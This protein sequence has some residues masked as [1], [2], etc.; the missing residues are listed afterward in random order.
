MYYKFSRRY[1]PELNSFLAAA[2]TI[3]KFNRRNI[4][5]SHLLHST[6]EGRSQYDVEL[7]KGGILA[8]DEIEALSKW[9]NLNFNKIA[10]DLINS[11]GEYVSPIQY[12]YAKHHGY[13]PFS[14]VKY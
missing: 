2:K 8:D 9:L 4:T 10:V 3:D 7:E 5:I 11:F 1:G 12:I 14:F 6:Q 13:L